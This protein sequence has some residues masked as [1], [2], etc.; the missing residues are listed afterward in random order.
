MKK[1]SILALHL[2]YGG[3]EKCITSLA[4]MLASYYEVEIICVYQLYEEPVF[5]LDERVSIQYLIHDRKPNQ[6]EFKEALSNKQLLKII[7]EGASGIKTLY[8]R[9]HKMIEAIKNSHSDIIIATRDIFDE[10]LSL[11]GKEDTLKIGWEHNHHHQNEKYA[12][13]IVRSC[14][15]LDHLVLVS[16]D[17]YKFYQKKMKPYH[18]RC[19]YIPNMLDFIPKTSSN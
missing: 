19:S 6:K 13:E 1:V 10:W 16:K 4:N 5:K 2:G 18:C 12:R 11:Y 17:L 3:I 15:D 7:K 9:K 14:K 8:L